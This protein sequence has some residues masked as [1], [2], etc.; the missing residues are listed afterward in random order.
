MKSTLE[1]LPE[2][3]IQ[4][5]LMSCEDSDLAR[6]K[7]V[8]KEM[9]MQTANEMKSR[10][11]VRFPWAEN[12]EAFFHDPEPDF[13]LYVV[14]RANF[15]IKAVQVGLEEEALVEIPKEFIPGRRICRY[16]LHVKM[17]RLK[18]PP[19]VKV[20]QLDLSKMYNGT[21][22]ARFDVH[23]SCFIGLS[24]IDGKCYLTWYH[25]TENMSDEKNLKKVLEYVFI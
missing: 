18:H 11:K 22:Y 25:D 9:S 15:T 24:E 14:A 6:L 10:C 1:T 8:S 20:I 5:I 21:Y 3:L 17:T 7:G 13:E 19:R 12:S 2:E 4:L 16:E 23:D